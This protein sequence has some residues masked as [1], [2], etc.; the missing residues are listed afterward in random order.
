M[1]LPHLPLQT[2]SLYTNRSSFEPAL[3]AGH[4]KNKCLKAGNRCNL[5]S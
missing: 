4:I 5:N 2:H 3:S 1:Y